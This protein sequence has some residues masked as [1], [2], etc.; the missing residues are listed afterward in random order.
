MKQNKYILILIFLTFNPLFAQET[1]EELGKV[2]FKVFKEQ[3][4]KTLETLTPTITEVFDFY[5]KIDSTL[6]FLKDTDFRRKQEHHDRQFKDK[7][8]RIMK[9][10]AGVDFKDAKLT[11]VKHI[12]KPL[13]QM[14]NGMPLVTHYLEIYFTSGDKKYSLLFKGLYKIDDIWKL[15]EDMRIHEEKENKTIDKR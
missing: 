3:D 6:P 7:C 4:T 9:G 5:T 2:V 8:T 15:G 12:E 11:E 1:P 13:G 10:E 14:P